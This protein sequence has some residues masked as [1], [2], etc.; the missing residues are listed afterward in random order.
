MFFFKTLSVLIAL[1]QSH[2][3]GNWDI[4]LSD[5]RCAVPL[6]FFNR[7][8][9]KRWVS[10]DFEDCM[11]LKKQF[12]WFVGELQWQ[13]CPSNTTERK[14]YPK[15]WTKHWGRQ[16]NKPATGVTGFTK[17]KQAVCRWNIIKHKKSL[18]TEVLAKICTP[19]A[20]DQYSR[21]HDFSK[22]TPDRGRTAVKRWSAT[23]LREET[24][25]T[26]QWQSWESLLLAKNWMMSWWHLRQIVG[27]RRRRVPEV[28]DER[29]K[30]KLIKLFD[31]IKK[32][33]M[34][35]CN[36]LTQSCQKLP[37]KKQETVQLM[38]ILTLH[39]LETMTWRSYFSM[40]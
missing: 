7:I 39:E 28:Y 16:Y 25:L 31:P 35:S 27:H 33:L 23:L 38:Q 22:Y 17:Q 3:E 32:V 29:L 2:R 8:N 26:F 6:F 10:L 12:S 11:S 15:W 34:K 4:H 13:L 20:E 24:H 14:W 5:V 40:K 36:S 30:K 18:F 21:H 37:D 1:H 19:E 9:Y